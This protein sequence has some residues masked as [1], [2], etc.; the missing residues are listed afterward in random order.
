MENQ[1]ALRSVWCLYRHNLGECYPL[2]YG[3]SGSASLFF[4]N[5][6]ASHP[7]R[8]RKAPAS[9]LAETWAA[10]YTRPAKRARQGLRVLRHVRTASVG[11]RFSRGEEAGKEGC[12]QDGHKDPNGT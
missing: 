8:K 6:M 10:T 7:T 11:T 12:E 5:G 4:Q 2:W 1:F 9:L 3:S